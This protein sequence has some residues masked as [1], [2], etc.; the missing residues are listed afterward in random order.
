MRKNLNKFIAF[1]IGLSVMTSTMLPAMAAEASVNA[2]KTSQAG[3]TV[4]SGLKVLSLETAIDNAVSKDNQ[5]KIYTAQYNYYKE[6]D[7]YYDEVDD[8]NGEDENDVNKESAKQSIAFR[9]DGVKYEITNLYNSIILMEKQVEQQQTVVNNKEIETRN[10]KLNGYHGLKTTVD[11]ENQEADLK[12]EKDTL[13]NYK[14][15]LKDLKGQL[16]LATGLE[17][18]KY[19]LDDN[20]DFKPFRIYGDVDDYIDERIN[21]ITKYTE[22]LADL[23]EDEVDDMKDD[24][25]DELDMPNKSDSKFNPKTGEV[26]ENGNEETKFDSQA[27]QAACTEVLTN[28]RTY[29]GKKLSLSTTKAQLNATRDTYKNSLRS[30]YTTILNTE[31][32]INSMINKI[33]TTNKTVAH[34][35][36]QYEL[37][38]MTKNEY[39]TAVTNCRALD[40]ALRQQINGYYQ[41]TET[42][43]RPWAASSG[44]SRG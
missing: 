13:E 20:I 14:N 10:F 34:L 5:I 29:L 6:L 27:Y 21:E 32:Q 26:D 24:D 3:T 39:D 43:N 1:G 41:L 18:E 9:R 44:A 2:V 11:I 7:D 38:L 22:E 17:V 23:Y 36:L 37:G 30:S 4:N 40:I 15:Q 16:S 35:K 28:Y 8:E 42:F 12:T 31:N 25:Y 19:I 33:N